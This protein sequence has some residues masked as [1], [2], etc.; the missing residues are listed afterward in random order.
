MDAEL[1]ELLRRCGA[2]PSEII[3]DLDRLSDLSDQQVGA[4]TDAVVAAFDDLRALP[5]GDRGDDWIVNLDMLSRAGQAARVELEGRP[6]VEE[7]LAAIDARVD[8]T[9]DDDEDYEP[10]SNDTDSDDAPDESESVPVSASARRTSPGDVGRRRP[11]R[12]RPRATAAAGGAFVTP[13][14]GEQI[15]DVG[16]VAQRLIDAHR[17]ARPDSGMTRVA[18]LAARVAPGHELGEDPYANTRAVETATAD[19]IT[20]SGG[21][22]APSD[23]SYALPEISEAARPVRDSLPAFQ[24]TRGGLR[25]ATP[26]G[27]ADVDLAGAD[28]AITVHTNTA[29]VAGADKGV[30]VVPCASFV[31]T[32]T[33]AVVRRLQFG[34]MGA[35]AFPEQVEAWTTLTLAAHARVAETQ[36]LDGILAASTDT[37][38]TRQLGATRDLIRAVAQ[39]AAG[40]RNRHRM[41]D[42]AVLRVL[43][44]SWSVDALIADVAIGEQASADLLRQSR[45]QIV[46]ILANLGVNVTFYVDTP[47]GLGQTFGAQSTGALDPFPDTVH[48]FLFHEGM[49]TFLDGGTLDLGIVRDSTLNTTNDFETFAET[50][51]AVAAVGHESVHVASPICV[52][53]ESQV[54]VD[55]GTCVGS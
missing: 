51:E 47:T 53:G 40:Y 52:N 45:T 39:A 27:L 17:D 48:W 8:G 42:D 25:F 50:F 30:Q 2:L 33:Y 43:M 21:F 16:A 4:T 29:D 15:G 1:L 24:A 35:R 36:L 10:D 19:A 22:C 20:A 9:P 23:V 49:F 34:N 14:G 28:A 12:T 5:E 11:A 32:N 31:E 13:V 54:A 41:G 37:T 44:P 46:S 3:D 55:A 6:S 26:P 38:T 18:R 7:R